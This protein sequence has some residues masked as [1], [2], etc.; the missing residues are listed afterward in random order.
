MKS[1][2]HYRAG[3]AAA[4]AHIEDRPEAPAPRAGEIQVRVG[5]S[6][7]HRG[8]LVATETGLPDGSA[9][10][11]L[12]TEAAG[13]VTAVGP[14][15]P[16]LQ[17]GGRVAVLPAP[18]AWSEHITVPAEAAVAVPFGAVPAVGRRLGDWTGRVVVD[19][20]NQFARSDP[21]RGLADVSPPTGKH[22]LFQG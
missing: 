18:G 5:V 17:A 3:D 6:P 22:F 14:S 20:T 7:V 13:V 15:V 19:M 21:Y 8:D 12:G 16:T 11:R 2:V 1:V 9:G 10:R 4:V